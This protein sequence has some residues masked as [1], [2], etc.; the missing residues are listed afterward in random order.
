MGAL[1]L[2][3]AFLTN[4]KYNPTLPQGSGGLS[5]PSAGLAGLE[6]FPVQ[7]GDKTIVFCSVSWLTFCINLLIGGGSGM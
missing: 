4:S 6:Q 1:G 5:C 2:S 3:T 7:K